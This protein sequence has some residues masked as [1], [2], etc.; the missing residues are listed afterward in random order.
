MNTTNWLALIS[1]MAG[2]MAPSAGWTQDQ[3]EGKTLYVAYCATCHGEGG[4][5]DGPAGLSLPVRPA[6]HTNG[7]AMNQLSD[8]FLMNIISKGGGAVGKSTFMP[9][10]GGALNEKQ[11]REIVSYIRSIAVPPKQAVK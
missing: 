5:G 3:A 2:L 8:S 6:D 4:K 1:F 9:A 7:A 10:W 11:I